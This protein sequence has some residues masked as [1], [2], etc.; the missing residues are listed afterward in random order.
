M[1]TDEYQ[2]TSSIAAL[3]LR[4]TLSG[5]YNRSA[6]AEISSL[7]AFSAGQEGVNSMEHRMRLASLIIPQALL[8]I[9]F[10]PPLRL[11]LVIAPSCALVLSLSLSL[12]LFVLTPIQWTDT[13]A[14]R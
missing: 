12:C 13:A 6:L 9:A 11:P 3:T 10:H 7:F 14:V 1:V 4:K 8:T 2:A 5:A